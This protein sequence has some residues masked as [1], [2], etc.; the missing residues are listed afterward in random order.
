MEYILISIEP[1]HIEQIR[2][3]NKGYE[4]RKFK[5]RNSSIHKMLIYSCLPLQKVV[6][7]CT[8]ECVLEDS[9]ENLWR[10]TSDKAGLSKKDFDKYFKGIEK[11]YAFKI[12]DVEFFPEPLP[13]S[14]FGIAKAPRSIQY[15]TL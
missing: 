12:T 5:I 15:I 14:E 13:L 4:F 7:K 2:L 1:K 10:R 8:L 6:A 11:G 9:P 3:G